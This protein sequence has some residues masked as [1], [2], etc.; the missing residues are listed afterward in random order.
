MKMQDVDAAPKLSPEADNGYL[1]LSSGSSTMTTGHKPTSFWETDRTSSTWIHRMFNWLGASISSRKKQLV[2]RPVSAMRSQSDEGSQADK[3]SHECEN[4]K[5]RQLNKPGRSQ[6]DTWRP[7][8]QRLSALCHSSLGVERPGSLGNQPGHRNSPSAEPQEEAQPQNTVHA[9]STNVTGNGEPLGGPSKGRISSTRVHKPGSKKE[10]C[11]QPYKPF[12]R[13]RARFHHG[14]TKPAA[15][16]AKAGAVRYPKSTYS[17]AH[18]IKSRSV[19]LGVERQPSFALVEKHR[20][21]ISQTTPTALDH[22]RPRKVVICRTASPLDTNVTEGVPPQNTEQ[23][24]DSGDLGDL[25]SDENREHFE[26]RHRSMRRRRSPEQQHGHPTLSTYPETS[27]SVYS[28]SEATKSRQSSMI[29][30]GNARPASRA[31]C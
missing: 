15:A 11:R 13:K 18:L 9:T 21:T 20:S 6:G 7:F 3:T 4:E 29:S 23:S 10:I 19:S 25:D 22:A 31:S 30:G 17:P 2:S 14:H 8:V 1:P 28:S 26:Q 5:R 16:T 27:S 12:P 24:N